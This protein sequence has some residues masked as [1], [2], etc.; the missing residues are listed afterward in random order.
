MAFIQLDGINLSFGDRQ[1]LS[2]T[3]LTI[4]PGSR[5]ALT[6]ANGSGKSTLMKIAAGEQEYDEGRIISPKGTR[7]AYL[8]QS[9]IIHKGKSLMDEAMDAFEELSILQKEADAIT[10]RLEK[11]EG[12]AVS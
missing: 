4:S 7:S 10:I 8:P 9:G 1:I 2:D 5:I 6:G 3:H 12:S 11:N